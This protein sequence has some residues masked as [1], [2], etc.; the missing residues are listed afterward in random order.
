MGGW[1]ENTVRVK[2]KLPVR[3]EGLLCLMAAM[4]G[5]GAC[6]S[7]LAAAERLSHQ[8]PVVTNIVQFRSLSGEQFLV[9]CAFELNGSVTLVDTNRHL[10]VL[11]DATDAVA[12]YV[13]VQNDQLAVGE[14]ISV[15]ASN[16]CPVFAR[17][18][19]YPHRPSGWDVRRRFEA[20]LNWGPYHLTRMRGWLRPP[21][22]GQY[23]LWIASDNS[24]ELWLSPGADPSNAKKIAS[25]PRFAWVD[26]HQWSRF[27]SQRSEPIWLDAGQSYYIEAVQEQTSGADNLAVAWQ[28][29]TITQSVITATHLTP[30][31]G[32]RYATIAPATN[33]I[34]R[35]YWTNYSAGDLAGL[36]AL[37]PFESALSVEQLHVFR[38]QP[39]PLPKPLPVAFHPE[40]LAT[41]NYRW[42]EAAGVVTFAG[43]GGDN[44]FLEL[45]DS[46]AQTQLRLMTGRQALP[47]L[48]RNVPVRVH[49]VCEGIFD[50]K[51]ALV[52]G[53]IW[54]TAANGVSVTMAAK[55][56][57]T[58]APAT[59][60]L[61]HSIQPAQTM[62]GFYQTRGVVTF[63]DRVFGKEWLF[64]QEGSAAVFV[65]LKDCLFKNQLKV[66]QWV[67]FGGALE[68]AKSFPTIAPLVVKEVGWRSMPAP[69]TEPIHFPIPDHRD[70]RWTE[71]EGVVRSVHSNG[72]LSVMGSKGPVSIW[73]GG[74]SNELSRFMD[75]K[76]CVRGV[77]SL[78]A[79]D[80]PLLLVPSRS[81]VEVAEPAPANPFA[82]P[83]RAIGELPREPGDPSSLHR[84]RVIGHVTLRDAESFI[85]QDATGGARVQTLGKPEA[86]IGDAV[87]VIGFPS[88]WGEARILTE[89]VVRAAGGL[90]R[91]EPARLDLTDTLRARQNGVLVRVEADLLA[92][93]TVGSSHIL[94]LREG[95]RIF[96]ATLPANHG[97]VATMIRGSR[98][99][100]TGVWDSESSALP[101]GMTAPEK[102]ALASLNIWL[103]TPADV[104]VLSGPPWWTWQRTTALIGTL[105][106]ILSGALL[107]V[108]L[109]RRRLNRQKAAQ[110]AASQQILKR[111]EDERQ[112]IAANLHDSLGQVLLAI[113]NQTLLALQRPPDDSAVCERL[114]EISGATSQALEEVR[115]ITHG[116]RPYQ[117]DRLGLTQALHATV[118][119]ASANSQILFASRVEDIDSIFDKDSEIHVYRI[120]QEALNNV[121]KHA[122]A[123][124]AAVVIKKRPA[125][126]LTSCV[127][128]SI[129]DNGRGFDVAARRASQPNDLGY[130]LSGIAE[131][132]RIL[133][134]NMTIDSRPGGG[135][136][137]SIEIPVHHHAAASL[138]THRG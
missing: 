73:I 101:A 84:V 121:L 113:K 119:R 128:I 19:Q 2:M 137:L 34:L 1:W 103:R 62:S 111:L 5:A 115:Q 7:S 122:A 104:K 14:T 130:G 126:A 24:S 21:A 134:G 127:S 87:E 46:K 136:S 67:E 23:T 118:S 68:A 129:R 97:A 81:F 52:P 26:P 96:T 56:E 17:F 13:A 80:N 22:S 42:V 82:T 124:E 116:L 64:V 63:N 77:L 53:W 18:S 117:L 138:N 51:G 92:Q 57:S 44:A 99:G 36:R 43:D 20:P 33:G 29:P 107:W 69:V 88:A 131:R 95:Q 47:Q 50:E 94:E 102:A 86:K 112:R 49:G 31:N 70:G 109:L 4:F 39:G 90:E 76:L 38:R 25:V 93:R 98:L 60:A 78:R 27:R 30:W 133:G 48:A 79:F 55:A 41:N 8:T 114:S 72:T 3:S 9:G 16:C 6:Q 61:P 37:R 28:G 66:G 65:S 11:Q 10:V 71:F 135:V 45:A 91:V 83:V 74:A 106:A 35:E 32:G 110:L 12:I 125:N 89:A 105:F 123:T 75:A 85:V 59:H 15:A 54:I 132:V 40:W 58:R 120:V 100:I 108:Y